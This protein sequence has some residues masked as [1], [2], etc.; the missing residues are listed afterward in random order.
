MDT[1]SAMEARPSPSV[2]RTVS[3]HRPVVSLRP[4]TRPSQRRVLL[5]A[6]TCSVSSTVLPVPSATVTVTVPA[7]SVSRVHVHPP[8]M[9]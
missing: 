3:S 2:R 6:S 9:A 1:T 4:C 8:P 5:P 7:V